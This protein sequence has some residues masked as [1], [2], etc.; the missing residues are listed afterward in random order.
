MRLVDG[1]QADPRMFDRR[2]KAL[3]VETFRRA[4]AAT[5]HNPIVRVTVDSFQTKRGGGEHL[6]ELQFTSPQE[7][8]GMEDGFAGLRRIE[9]GGLDAFRL[10]SVHLILRTRAKDQR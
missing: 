4:V 9:G 1:N 3:V 5:F 10:E 7:I 2:H 6:Q 8:V